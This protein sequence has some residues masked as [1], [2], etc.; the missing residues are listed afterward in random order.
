MFCTSRQKHLP[1]VQFHDFFQRIYF[2]LLTLHLLRHMIALLKLFKIGFD[3]QVGIDPVPIRR[4]NNQIGIG[5][6]PKCRPE[7]IQQCADVPGRIVI[8]LIRPELL[9]KLSG[10][11]TSVPVY[12][13]KQKD[14]AAQRGF[15][16]RFGQLTFGS[17]YLQTA[18]QVDDDF[19]IR[20]YHLRRNA[21]LHPV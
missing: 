9:G 17:I 15:K 3:L 20:L 13:Q 10:R 2:L 8:F 4:C 21:H 11:H 19:V 7:A 6:K 16:L 5:D 12:H 14:F 18:K 1:T